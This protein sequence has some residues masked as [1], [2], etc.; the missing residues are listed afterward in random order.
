[1]NAEARAT[2]DPA[3]ETLDAVR[4]E[5]FDTLQSER[6]AFTSFARGRLTWSDPDCS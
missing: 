4:A 2:I 3:F 6:I 1:M 5:P